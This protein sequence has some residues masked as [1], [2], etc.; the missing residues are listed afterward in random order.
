MHFAPHGVAASAGDP[1]S[2][3]GSAVLHAIANAAGRMIRWSLM[4]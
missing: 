3:T 2:R 4:A 1:P